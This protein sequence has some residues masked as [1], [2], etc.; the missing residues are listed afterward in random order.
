[1]SGKYLSA[2]DLLTGI[3]GTPE[4]YDVPGVGVV[5]LRALTVAEVQALYRQH[6]D[7]S[8]ALMVGSIEYG[9]VEPKLDA[10]GAQQLM[11][12]AAGPVTKLAQR[13]MQISGMSEVEKAGE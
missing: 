5:R 4:D 3:M 10:D 6:K 11:N 7:D 9:L 1:M 8:M 2:A 13:I 12:A